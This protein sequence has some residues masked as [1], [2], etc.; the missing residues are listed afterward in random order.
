[1]SG[2]C[3]RVLLYEVSLREWFEGSSHSFLVSSV[4]PLPYLS[5][6]NI[7]PVPPDHS[8]IMVQ[9]GLF[10]RPVNEVEETCHML[11]LIFS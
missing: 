11:S 10:M 9:S 4:L 5:T 3:H 7:C 8:Y 1:M 6:L 2:T